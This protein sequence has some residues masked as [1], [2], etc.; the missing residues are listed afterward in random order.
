[1]P[2]HPFF[3]PLL[4]MCILVDA[5]NAYDEAIIKIHAQRLDVRCAAF[6]TLFM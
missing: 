5:L 6:E 3:W 1:M 4:G 2:L